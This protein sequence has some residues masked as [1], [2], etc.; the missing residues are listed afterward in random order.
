MRFIKYGAFIL[1]TLVSSYLS[2][3]MLVGL[4]A[5]LAGKITLGLT[6][7]ALESTKVF[8]LLKLEYILYQRSRLDFKERSRIKR[9]WTSMLIYAALASISIVASLG[10]T[11]VTVDK[12]VESSKAV[13]VSA[14]E[15]YSFDIEQ[16]L[17][18]LQQKDNQIAVMSKQS[19]AINADLATGLVKLSDATTRLAS[20]RQQI[21]EEIKRLRG[22]QNAAIVEVGKT[23]Q[24]NVYGMFV[25]MGNLAG[26]IPEKTVMTILLLLISVLL[27]MGMIYTSPTINIAEDA[28][29]EISHKLQPA[30]L[31]AVP[32]PKPLVKKII[33]A[34]EKRRSKALAVQTLP[35]PLAITP[36]DIH[37]TT[38]Q[39]LK[40]EPEPVALPVRSSMNAEDIRNFLQQILQPAKG[41]E[42]K[43][44]AQLS[45]ELD[46]SVNKINT[47]LDMIGNTK[48]TAG[49]L[50]TQQNAHWHLN[51]TKDMTVNLVLKYPLIINFIK[52]IKNVSK[53]N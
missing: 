50:L 26:G 2:V 11:L 46:I 9:P 16:Q 38:S 45:Y 23:E 52:G 21:V 3:N 39:Q 36:Q 34:P 49:P 5:D 10:F 12:Q 31:A 15:D 33:E 8:A 51:Y 28:L 20:E 22:L 30:P 4:G 25:L 47:L 41:V 7:I 44:A 14:T 13:F 24:T 27:E 53:A 29:H 6:S 37:V 40:T 17:V 1:L 18:A 35:V 43:T 42:L 48:G 32:T 19:G